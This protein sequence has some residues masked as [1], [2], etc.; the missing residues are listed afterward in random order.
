MGV[1]ISRVQPTGPLTEASFQDFRD[2]LSEGNL[3]TIQRNLHY[4]GRAINLDALLSERID[5]NALTWKGQRFNKD[6][7]TR[8]QETLNRKQEKTVTDAD[9]NQI[10]NVLT[11]TPFTAQQAGVLLNNMQFQG[12]PIQPPQLMSIKEHL[13][14]FSWKGRAF[15]ADKAQQ[16]MTRL[17][18][19]FHNA[20]NADKNNKNDKNSKNDKTD[21]TDKNDKNNKN[22]NADKNGKNNND[23]GKTDKNN[24]TDNA[25]KN[26]NADKHDKNNKTDN[27]DKDNKTDKQLSDAQVHEIV[28]ALTSAQ[29]SE[30]LNGLE[31]KKHT[32]DTPG[33]LLISC[34]KTE[35]LRCQGMYFTHTQLKKIRHALKNYQKELIQDF[36]KALHGDDQAYHKLRTSSKLKHAHKK[37]IN[38]MKEV[39]HEDNLDLA[40]EK[41]TLGGH[42]LYSPDEVKHILM[43]ISETSL[44]ADTLKRLCN[45]LQWNNRSLSEAQMNEVFFD[46]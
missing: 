5:H 20:K 25:D 16:L 6:Q 21:K 8:L 12:Q 26:T 1:D 7:Y 37:N 11:T 38:E 3:D 9:L 44:D 43:I 27:A 31:Y 2:N 13:H 39:F 29:H 18:A 42:S 40:L 4:Q 34:R 24:K 17:D 19:Y 33:L 22:T 14:E 30:L 28:S 36:Q 45:V 15:N 35:F 46:Y 23:A 32:V 10:F 41:M